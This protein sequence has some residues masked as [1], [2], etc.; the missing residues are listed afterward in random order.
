M[1]FM[2]IFIDESGIHRPVGKSTFVLVYVE[3]ENYNKL[4]SA[5][6]EIEKELGIKYFHWA[7]TVWAIKEKLIQK[8]LDL[9]F[10]LKIA[11]IENPVNPSL[12]MERV[13]TH[14][15][16][17]R[18]IVKILI[19]GKKPKWYEKKIKKILRDKMITIKKLK[20]VKDESEAGIR[21]ADLLAGLARWHFENIKK[22]KIEKYYQRLKSKILVVIE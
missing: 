5:F 19:D 7:E 1:F 14:M 3:I 2:L 15:I 8:I 21:L 13:L 4:S 16:V 18:N 17:E 9:D 12:E 22:D 11:V 6:I 10:N 20:T